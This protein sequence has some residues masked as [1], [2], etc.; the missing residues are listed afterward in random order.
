MSSTKQSPS[1]AVRKARELI[2]SA[3]E[4]ADSI[5]LEHLI[6][7]QEIIKNLNFVR[8]LE[9]VRKRETAEGR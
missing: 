8:L 1:E 5:A 3:L 2:F 6:S 7:L 9:E 4:N